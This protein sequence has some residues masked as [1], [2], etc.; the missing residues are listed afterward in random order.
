MSDDVFAALRKLLVILIAG[1]TLNLSGANLFAQ[2]ASGGSLRVTVV[3]Q[4]GAVIVGA[5]VTV[6]AADEATKA[7]AIAPVRTSD[8]GVAIVP[9]LTPGRYT[10]QVE[11][12]GFEKRLL[13]DVR[14]RNGE[15]RQVAVLTIER[16]QT[17]VTVEQDKQQA[18][19]DRNGPSFGTTLTREQIEA[20]SDDPSILQQQLQDMAG[21][22]AVIR[23]DGFEG[24]ALPAKAMIRSIRIARDQ[25]AAEYHSAGGVAIEIITQPGVGPIRYFST[26][27]VR[28]GSLS[29]RSPFVP[30]QHFGPVGRR[31]FSRSRGQLLWSDADAQSA[32]EMPTIR[33]LDAFNSGGAQ[34]AGADHARTL[35]FASDLDYVRGRHSIRTGFVFDSTWYHSDTKANYLGTFT[36]T[37]LQ[38]Y[39][40]NQPSNYTRRIGDPAIAYDN[41]QGGIYVQDDIRV[42]KNLT[43]TPGVRYELQTHVRNYANIGPRIGATW[44]PLAGGQTTLRGSAGIF[45]DWLPT[46]AY[47]QALRVDGFHQ[48]E[49]NI[50]DP[51]C[52]VPATSG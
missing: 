51:S 39:E 7:V 1:A 23:I 15:N 46:S 40:T 38:A 22:G 16:V 47:D 33:V 5:T 52:P 21:P 20:L 13:T 3:D 43:L 25:F 11:F 44:A 35:D 28:D 19:A 4:T 17:A 12:P 41:V 32:N 31:A 2:P 34:R 10:V 29:G 14:V 24:G 26:V 45:Y 18:A 9:A 36:F 8:T 48:Q 37:N 30:A 49:I 42:R 27:L 6:A 50:V